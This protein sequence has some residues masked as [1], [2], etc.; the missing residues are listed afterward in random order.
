VIAANATVIGTASS[1][2]GSASEDAPTAGTSRAPKGG[3]TI[4]IAKNDIAGAGSKLA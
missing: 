3:S 1:F 4:V 2:H